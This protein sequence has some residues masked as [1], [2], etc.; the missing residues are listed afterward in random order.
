MVHALVVE[1]D[2]SLE[3]GTSQVVL[4]DR[5]HRFRRQRVVAPIL[6]EP[7][8]QYIKALNARLQFNN[9]IKEY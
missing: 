8:S 5:L 4:H 3:V 2:E 7:A 9:K 6:V 1:G